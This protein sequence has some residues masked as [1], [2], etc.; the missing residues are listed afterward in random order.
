MPRTPHKC[1]VCEGKKP[2]VDT[3]QACEKGVVWEPEI[4]EAVSTQDL[5]GDPLNL[6]TRPR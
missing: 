5:N 6:E 4:T 3:C 2:A 1:P